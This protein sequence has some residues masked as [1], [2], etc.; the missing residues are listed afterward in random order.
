MKLGIVAG[1]YA[2]GRMDVDRV[3]NAEHIG[4]DSVWSAEAYGSDAVTPLAFLAARTTR[5]KLGTGIM[6]LAG[7]SPANCAMTMT[8]LDMLSGGRVIVGLGLSGPQVVE[9]WHGVSYRKPS[10]WLREYITILRAI[11]AREAPVE[12]EGEI[13]QL[14]YHGPGATGL[15]KPLRSTLHPRQLP[16]YLA[17]MGPLNTR[18]TAELADGWLPIW[19][20]PYQPNLFRPILEEGFKRAGDGKSWKDF[21]VAARC[22]VV[23]GDDVG[24]CLARLKPRFALYIGGMGARDMNFY[25]DLAHKL[26][27]GDAAVRIQDLYLAGRKDEAAA[28][29]PDEF[30]DELSLC[31][32]EA[33]IREHFRAWEDAGVTTLLIDSGQPEAF[34]LM[35]EIAGAPGET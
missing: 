29:V 33:R 5:I 1:S 9:G 17:T 23:I 14:P 32:P 3:L 22:T 19:L 18:L 10:R 34:K 2:D 7:R 26:G 4:Y 24:A 31:G 12:F 11:W 27:Y 35:A 30:C 13:Y 28:A 20:S 6:Q 25:N 16:I 15:G 21:D 8:T